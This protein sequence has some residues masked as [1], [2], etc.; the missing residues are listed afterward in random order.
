MIEHELTP[1]AAGRGPLAD[2]GIIITRPARQAGM[3]AEKL[4]VMGARPIVFPAIVVL[5][6]VDRSNL[7][8]AHAQLPAYN[9][10]FFVSS[11]AAEY[12][13]PQGVHWPRGV[14]AYA[15]GPGTAAVLTDLGVGDVRYPATSHDSEGLLAL[16]ALQAVRGQRFAIFRGDGGRELLGTTLVSRGATVDYVACYRRTPPETGAEGLA[17]VLKVGDAHALTLT[18]TEGID[19]LWRVLDADSC[20]RLRRLRTFAS[21]PRVVEAARAHGLAVHPTG[22]GDMGMIAA[23]LEWFALHP[24]NAT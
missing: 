3:F 23:L 9:G 11:N 18:S 15:P 8:A 19:N 7:D 6:P 12:G 13:V 20:V 17:A 16:P 24:V 1:P 10:V 21:H 22:A 5:P 14:P 2:A 4:G